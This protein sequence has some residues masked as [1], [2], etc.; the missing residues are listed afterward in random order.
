MLFCVGLCFRV[1]DVGS[2]WRTFSNDRSAT[3]RSRVGQAEV[4]GRGR[5][6]DNTYDGLR[7]FNASPTLGYQL[8]MSLLSRNGNLL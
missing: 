8:I 1:I 2:E 7:Y 3:D 4:S 6:Y 5:F